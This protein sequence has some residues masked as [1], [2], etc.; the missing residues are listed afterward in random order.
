MAGAKDLIVKPIS[1]KGANSFIVKVH[2]SG[3]YTPDEWARVA[4]K[5]YTKHSAN[6]IVAEINMGG[7]LVERKGKR[8]MFWGCARYP[9]CRHTQEPPKKARDFSTA[10]Q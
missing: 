1:A 6:R 4:I 7:D 5:A 3:K 2:Y 10:G 9:E 8:G